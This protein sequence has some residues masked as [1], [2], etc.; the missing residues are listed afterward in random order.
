MTLGG[1][2]TGAA[3]ARWQRGHQIDSLPVATAVASATLAKMVVEKVGEY[4]LR[5]A[6]AQKLEDPKVAEAF[7]ERLLSFS[8]NSIEGV[9]TSLPFSEEMKVRGPMLVAAAA[10][11]IAGGVI[12]AR[13]GVAYKDSLELHSD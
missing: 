3:M 6:V 5:T 9:L 8:H 2:V 13:A 10:A 11:A 4:P 1:A 12:G 7:L